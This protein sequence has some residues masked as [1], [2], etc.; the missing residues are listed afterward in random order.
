MTG[1]QS[2]RATQQNGYTV[3]QIDRGPDVIG[4]PDPCERCDARRV[5]GEG[6][7]IIEYAHGAIIDV[8]S[9]C[10][11]EL[12]EDEI[13]KKRESKSV[14]DGGAEPFWRIKPHRE[15]LR[16]IGQMRDN[17]DDLESVVREAEWVELGG[18]GHA[19]VERAERLC[20]AV[21]GSMPHIL[22]SIEELAEGSR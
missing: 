13:D 15:I 19:D 17:L 22:E 14:A 5:V 7:W 6:S 10:A 11:S 1:E 21:E 3:V 8:C 18:R 20:E 2:E 4:E 12:E 16:D 9:A